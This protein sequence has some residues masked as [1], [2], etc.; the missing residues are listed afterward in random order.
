MT[1]ATVTLTRETADG[2]HQ[3]ATQLGVSSTELAERA[4][5]QYLRQESEKKVEQ[6]ET[7]YRQQHPQ[8]L[9]QFVGQYI[10]MHKGDVIDHD[11][12]ELRLYLRVRQ[13]YPSTGVLIK[14]VSP[15]LETV[16]QIRSPKLEYD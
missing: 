16:W 12:D 10:A 4:I 13:Q 15:R 6:E 1:S 8:L 3:A 9:E 5:R 11:A 2:L 7:A 14:H